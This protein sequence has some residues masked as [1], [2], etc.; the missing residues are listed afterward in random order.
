MESGYIKRQST[1]QNVQYMFTFLFNPAP[2]A[3]AVGV[4]VWTQIAKYFN[5]ALRGRAVRSFFI[6]YNSLHFPRL[7]QWLYVNC[8]H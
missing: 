4:C 3:V 5:G 1:K 2:G 8:F 6:L 7:L